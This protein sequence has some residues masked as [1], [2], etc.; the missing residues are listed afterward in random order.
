M[1]YFLKILSAL[2]RVSSSSRQVKRFYLLR[3]KQ[4]SFTLTE[5]SLIGEGMVFDVLLESVNDE[6]GDYCE[7]ATQGDIDN[8]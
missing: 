7:V 1:Q 6:N 2:S 4:L 5:L 3:C 8:W